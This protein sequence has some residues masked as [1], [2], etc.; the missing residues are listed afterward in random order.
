MSEFFFALVSYILLYKYVALFGISFIAALLIPLP[1]NTTLIAAAAFAGQGYLNIYTVLGTA[2]AANILGDVVGFFIAQTYGKKF[3]MR[4]GLAKL[5]TSPRYYELETF[6]INHCGKTIF[7]TRFF[8]GVGPLVNI[9]TGLSKEVSFKK[10]L[11]YGIPGE[12]VY[13]L[14]LGLPGFFL[15]SSWQNLIVSLESVSSVLAFAL[16]AYGIYYFFIRTRS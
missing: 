11:T 13:V 8:G 16:V 3:L 2:L 5:I 6:M 15:G 9:L 4:I 12:C 14:S 7:T 10:F 1:S